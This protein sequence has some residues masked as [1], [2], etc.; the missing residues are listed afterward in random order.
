MPELEYS[1][2]RFGI[3]CVADTRNGTNIHA[4]LLRDIRHCHRHKVGLVTVKEVFMLHLYDGLHGQGKGSSSLFHSLYVASCSLHF[5]LRIEKS[6]FFHTVQRLAIILIAE[7]LLLKV[8]RNEQLRQFSIVE[9][10]CHL[11]VLVGV[12]DKVWSHLLD[13]SAHSLAERSP[14]SWVQLSEFLYHLLRLIFRSL[15]MLTN[16]FPMLLRKVVEIVTYHPPHPSGK[17]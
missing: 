13:A 10:H 9:G 5:L 17:S 4:Y 12:D 11:S 15:E 2:R 16:L 8:V 14:R 3:L 1:P 7:H 6:L